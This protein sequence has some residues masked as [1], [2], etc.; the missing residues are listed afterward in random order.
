[1]DDP[2]QQRPGWSL[3]WSDEFR[4]SRLARGRRLLAVRDRGGPL[5][6]ARNCSITPTAPPTRLWM[7]R[8]ISP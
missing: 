7:A 3:V 6:Q 8:A 4:R 1:M 5:G 2:T